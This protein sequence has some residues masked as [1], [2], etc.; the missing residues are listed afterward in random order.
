MSAPADDAGADV[1]V[2]TSKSETRRGGEGG[3]M[4]E[5]VAFQSPLCCQ[6]I[7]CYLVIR[8]NKC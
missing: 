4:L 1:G 7:R 8:D 6:E 5:P 3:R 2:R